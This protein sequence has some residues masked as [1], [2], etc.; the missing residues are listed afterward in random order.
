M[1]MIS[2]KAFCGPRRGEDRTRRSSLAVVNADGAATA[3]ASAAEA[4]YVYI[5]EG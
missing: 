3:L 5:E 4:V 2:L 1:A